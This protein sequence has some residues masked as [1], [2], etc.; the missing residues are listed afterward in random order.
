M[1]LNHDYGKC[2]SATPLPALPKKKQK[3]RIQLLICGPILQKLVLNYILNFISK[4]C[5][6]VLVVEASMLHS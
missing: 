4:I 1:T 6:N 3:K 2:D 5:E